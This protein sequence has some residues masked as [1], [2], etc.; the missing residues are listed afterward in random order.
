MPSYRSEKRLKELARTKKREE[1][2]Q[3]K[4]VRKSGV[5]GE[6]VPDPELPLEGEPAEAGG[7]VPEEEEPP[8]P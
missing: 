1:K 4:L 8:T 2:R 7:E 5:D 6:A 3:K